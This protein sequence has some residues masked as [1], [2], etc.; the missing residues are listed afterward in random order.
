[1]AARTPWTSASTNPTTWPAA[2]TK[3]SASPT[4]PAA[5]TATS[6]TS[7]NAS[8]SSPGPPGRDCR[9]AG[10]AQSVPGGH[11]AATGT[12]AHRQARQQRGR[13]P[14]RGGS[15]PAREGRVTTKGKNTTLP[16]PIPAHRSPPLIP[17]AA[18]AAAAFYQSGRKALLR[19][20]VLLSIEPYIAPIHVGSIS[21]RKCVKKIHQMKSQ[22]TI[23]TGR[24]RS[25]PSSD[26]ALRLKM[27]Q[28]L[29]RA[30]AR[31]RAGHGPPGTGRGPFP[32][33]TGWKVEKDGD[34]SPS[35]E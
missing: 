28:S 17:P 14:L 35:P 12:R 20:V 29:A 34:S 27:T 31:A 5:P 10:G 24:P 11:C 2:S 30:A 26:G 4:A 15:T 21:L 1:T 22:M 8:S 6:C 32:P 33:G 13:F 19:S 7:T 18:G 16:G 25:Y 3:A 23:T 9:A